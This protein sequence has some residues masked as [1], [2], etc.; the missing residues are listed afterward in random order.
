VNPQARVVWDSLEFRTPAV[1][2]SVERL[3]EAELQWQPPNAATTKCL[4]FAE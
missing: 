1:L 2:Q 3:S 4:A